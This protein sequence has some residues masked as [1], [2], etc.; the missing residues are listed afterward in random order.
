MMTNKRIVK[1]LPIFLFSLLLAS[2]VVLARPEQHDVIIKGATIVDGTGNKAFKGDIAI[3]G[4]RIV[5]VGKVSGKAELIIDGSGLIASPGF[6]DPHNHADASI[7]KYPLAENLVMQGVTTFV[8]GNCGISLAPRSDKFFVW[9]GFGLKEEDAGYSLDW[10]TFGEYLTKLDQIDT[11]LNFVPLVGHGAVRYHVMGNDFR[12]TANAKETEKMRTLVEEA[13]KNGAFGLS[14]G[15]DYLP[16]NFSDTAEVISLAEVASKHGGIYATHTRYNNSDWPTDNPEE[17]SYG[18][19]LGSPENIWVG[20]YHGVIEALEVGKKANLPVHISHV[21]NVFRIPQPHPEYLEEAAAKATLWVFDRAR[22]EGVDM[23]FDVIATADSISNEGKLINAFY[24][25]RVKGLQWVHGISKEEFVERLKT[26]E[27]RE[28]LRRVHKSA[29]LKLGFVHTLVDPYW[30]NC[31]RIVSSKNTAY[32]GKIL[33]DIAEAQ[34][35]DPL[36]MIFDILVE[37]PETTWVQ[38]LDRRGTDIM[39]ATFLKHSLAMPSTDTEALPAKPEK[40]GTPP[41]VAYGL[42]PHYFGH[43]I[44]DMSIVGLEEAVKKATSFP[45]QRFG[46]KERGTLKPGAYAD[47]VLFDFKT[48]KGKANFRNP[49]LPPDGIELVMVNGQ[50]VYKDKAH[51]GTKPGK[52]LRRK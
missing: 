49:T 37:D 35:T 27:F 20:L 17:V 13:M 45:A 44:R 19:Y 3:K 23:T 5:Q 25:R 11:S 43:Y 26:E 30:F 12:R 1:M 21:A 16:G 22:D 38:F 50:I 24:S 29:R 4:E 8:G 7:I 10:Q 32:E 31:F 48:I 47:I 6:I 36:E 9:Q 40:G 41:P 39:N 33:G 2:S 51:T 18:R 14:S 15:L 34:D 52:V 28:R 42:Y 46:I